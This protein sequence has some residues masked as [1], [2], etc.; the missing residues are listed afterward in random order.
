MGY[1]GFIL[2]SRQ[3]A[4]ANYSPADALNFARDPSTRDASIVLL[5]PVPVDAAGRRVE[6]NSNEQVANYAPSSIEDG[7]AMMR[8][9]HR[10]RTLWHQGWQHSLIPLM[11]FPQSL[12]AYD[13]AFD[14]ANHYRFDEAGYGFADS[15]VSITYAR[16]G[17]GAW[18]S[19]FQK[20]INSCGDIVA[21]EEF[22]TPDMP[23]YHRIA[24]LEMTRGNTAERLQKAA[25]AAA[26][27]WSQNANQR[28]GVPAPQQSYINQA[29]PA[30]QSNSSYPYGY[31]PHPQSHG[32]PVRQAGPLPQQQ[33]QR[34]QQSQPQRQ[35]HAPHQH[36]AG[37]Y[38]QGPPQGWNQRAPQDDIQVDW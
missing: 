27:K 16:N 29:P 8:P 38:E 10:A 2:V 5:P 35:N 34:Q 1:P 20:P 13:K 21:P 17:S 33:P 25:E 12:F 18:V 15:V 31:Q 26:Q 19:N 36:Q 7:L 3:L 30:P 24:A 11:G 22:V 37:G 28:Q 9:E 23:E 14:A 32:V 4:P 6:A